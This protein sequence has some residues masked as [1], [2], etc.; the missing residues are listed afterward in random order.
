MRGDDPLTFTERHRLEGLPDVIDRLT[1]EIAKLED[2][3][4]QPDLYNKEPAKF[5]KGTEALIE[6]QQALAKAEA[7]WMRLEEKL[8]S[9]GGERVSRRV[10]PVWRRGSETRRSR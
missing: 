5:A 9:A 4:A 6:R 10:V 2:F 1:A 8:E 7:D 3:L